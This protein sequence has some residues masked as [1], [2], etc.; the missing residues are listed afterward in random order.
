MSDDATVVAPHNYKTV[1]ENERVRLLEYKGKPGDKTGMH[2]HPDVVAYA[3]TPAKFKFS[4]PD[5]QEMEAE[6]KTGEAMFAPAMSHI[7]E[8]TGTND[9]HV[10]LFELK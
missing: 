10:L 3:M 5:G 7:T 4:F 2:A 9:A 8:N 1:F 6:L